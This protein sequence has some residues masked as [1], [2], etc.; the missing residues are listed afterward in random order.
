[1]CSDSEKNMSAFADQNHAPS[2]TCVRLEQWNVKK[3]T[4]LRHNGAWYHIS[5]WG[6]LWEDEN[7]FTVSVNVHVSRQFLGW[8]FSLGEGVKIISPDD[9]VDEMKQEIER[10]IRQ[11]K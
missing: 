4:E 6:L 8:V 1:M 11:Y 5:P 7:Y 9:V 3:E 10:L 2:L